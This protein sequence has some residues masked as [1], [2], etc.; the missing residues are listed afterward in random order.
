MAILRHAVSESRAVR[1][2]E[3][4][5]NFAALVK[6]ICENREAGAGYLQ[7]LRESRSEVD[8][9]ATL[10]GAMNEPLFMLREGGRELPAPVLSDGTLRFAAVAAL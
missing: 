10:A 3:R 4:G 8:D 6:R 1:M 2:G 5:E 7:W 9:V